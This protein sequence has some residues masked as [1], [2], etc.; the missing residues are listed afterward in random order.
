[1]TGTTF[2][3]NPR[4]SSDADRQY[5]NAFLI[6]RSANAPPPNPLLSPENFLA[7]QSNYRAYNRFIAYFCVL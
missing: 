7:N 2:L 5:A 1:M 6:N 3:A 4:I